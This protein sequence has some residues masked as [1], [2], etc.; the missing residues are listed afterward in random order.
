MTGALTINTSGIGLSVSNANV[1]F[2]LQVNSLNVTTNTVTTSSSGQVVL[3][4]F[5][6]TQLASAKYFIQANSTLDYH[7]TEIILVQ[8]GTNAYLTEYGSIQTGASLGSFSA[9]ISGGDARLLFNA[10][11]S[12]NTIRSVRYGIIK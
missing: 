6:T 9:D 4:K 5:P 11:N 7:T 2:S 8:D 1:T 3:D 10:T 12:I